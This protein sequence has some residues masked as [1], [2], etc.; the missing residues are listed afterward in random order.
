MDDFPRGVDE[1]I[2]RLKLD[3]RYPLAQNPLAD[4]RRGIL[5][6]FHGYSN[7]FVELAREEPHWVGRGV[8][9]STAALA[10]VGVAHIWF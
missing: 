10:L 4:N 8:A 3:L 9:W 6:L 2:L 5:D 7:L 1:A